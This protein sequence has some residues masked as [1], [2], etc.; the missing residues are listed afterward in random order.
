MTFK[1]FELYINHL[2]KGD[3][4]SLEIYNLGLDLS[5]TTDD[6]QKCISILLKAHYGEDGAEW[7][8]WFIYEKFSNKADPLTAFEDGVEICKNIEEL[9]V[10]VEEIRKSETFKEYIPKDPLTDEERQKIIEDL[11]G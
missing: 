9:W 3:N 5:Q 11:F 1:A 6:Y 8:D 10:M 4:K 7:I 2:T